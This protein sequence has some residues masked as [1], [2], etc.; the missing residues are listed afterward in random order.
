MSGAGEGGRRQA[1]LGSLR[2][3]GGRTHHAGEPH[4]RDR[5]QGEDDRGGDRVGVVVEPELH[6]LGPRVVG[7]RRLLGKMMI[8][9]TIR[10]KNKTPDSGASR[11]SRPRCIAPPTR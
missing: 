6:D 4:E 1:A 3:P 7:R 5:R 11:S 8:A 10:R 2:R 9:A